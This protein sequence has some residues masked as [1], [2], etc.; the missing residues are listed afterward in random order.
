MKI[1]VIMGFTN[2]PKH[3]SVGLRSISESKA[4]DVEVIVVDD[5]SRP[6]ED[7]SLVDVSRC[8]FPVRRLRIAP[9]RKRHQNGCVPY[10]AA[11]SHAS[12]DVVLVQECST[13][14]AGD[15]LAH[16]EATWS[17]PGVWRPYGC[18]SLDWP[19]TK[20][21]WEEESRWPAGGFYAGVQEAISPTVNIGASRD[22]QLSWYCHT[23]YRR[24]PWWFAAAIDRAELASMGGFDL[25]FAHGRAWDDCDFV[26]RFQL[27]GGFVEYVDEPFVLHQA[28]ALHDFTTMNERLY[29]DTRKGLK[30][31]VNDGKLFNEEFPPDLAVEMR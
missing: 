26:E 31:R 3:L 14:H 23:K 10:N 2:R 6:G 9:E 4:S 1:S 5:G 27:K 20:K 12:G 11:L 28:H 24:A 19:V 25:R 22:L 21:I 30:W 13:V 7:L 18:Y 15:V 17:G 29:K 16:L 8:R